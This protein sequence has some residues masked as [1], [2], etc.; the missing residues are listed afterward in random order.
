MDIELQ[1]PHCQ[2]WI[3]VARGELNCRIFR[4]AVY[5]ATLAPLNPHAP[6]EQCD[7]LLAAGALLGCAGPFQVVDGPDG[8]L[9]AVVCDY[10]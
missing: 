5:A 4:H 8:A 6:K 2:G 3:V 10:I 9:T 1:C 7:A